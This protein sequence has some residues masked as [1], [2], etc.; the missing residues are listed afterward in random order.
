MAG[1]QENV[2]SRYADG[3]WEQRK[4]SIIREGPV[5]LHVNGSELVTLMCTPEHL[6]WLALGFLRS[7]GIITGLNDVRLYKVCPGETCVDIWLRRA[8]VILP[9]T[10]TITS[11]CGGGV[12]FA[13]LAATAVPVGDELR[14]TAP[15]ICKLMIALIEAGTLYRQS[16]GVHTAALA[17]GEQLIRVVED[18]ARHNCIDKLWGRCLL[19]GIPTQAAILLTT[20]RISSEMLYKSARMGVE[21]VVSRTSPTSLS[22]AL[23]SNWNLTLI[24]YVRHDSLNVYAGQG[25]LAAGDTGR[26]NAHE[27]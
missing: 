22:V 18:V 10:R 1:N 21:A 4:G 11:G 27:G 19:E 3:C 7:E 2:F 17:R 13:D 26:D 8:D 6:D 14:V 9:S 20:G 15:Q 5:R 25:R 16:R 12:T 23:A 24:G